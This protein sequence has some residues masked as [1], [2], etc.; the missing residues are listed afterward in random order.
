MAIKWS[1]KDVREAVEK[2]AMPERNSGG[3][4]QLLQQLLDKA[5]RT[6]TQIKKG[7]K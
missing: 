5:K 4:N 2:V 6:G 1:V 3:G 7:F